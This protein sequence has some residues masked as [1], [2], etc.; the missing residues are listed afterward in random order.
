VQIFHVE[1]LLAL[2]RKVRRIGIPRK[3]FDVS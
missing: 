1:Y 2:H 3:A